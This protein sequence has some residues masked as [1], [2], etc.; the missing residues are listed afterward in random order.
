[1]VPSK[2]PKRN[3]QFDHTN[4][5]H[6]DHSSRSRA[7]SPEECDREPTLHLFF[8]SLKTNYAQLDISDTSDL[9]NESDGAEQD[10]W[11]EVNSEEFRTAMAEMDNKLQD[12]DWVPEHLQRKA[13]MRAKKKIGEFYSF[14]A[15]EV[16][17]FINRKTQELC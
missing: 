7:P 6:A 11:D 3:P 9:E 10:V 17:Y 5:D 2:R 1:M 16:A 13:A 4:S 8:D 12:P 14:L 15:N